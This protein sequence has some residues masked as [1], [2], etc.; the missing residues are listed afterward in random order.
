MACDL[1]TGYTWAGCDGIPGG[2]QVVGFL[3]YQ[4]KGVTFTVTNGVITAWTPLSAKTFKKYEIRPETGF[5]TDNAPKDPK[6]GG[7]AYAPTVNLTLSTLETT[8]RRE[9][10]L[11]QQNN[12]IVMTKDNVGKFRVGG[13]Y[14]GMQLTDLQAA[15]GTLFADGQKSI[16]NFAGVDT[17]PMLEM[18][19]AL[20]A[21][22]M[23]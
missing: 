20:A 2:I 1:T 21:T 14:Y 22:L 12:L 15:S 6:T 4:Y 17:Q 16:M 13:F 7:Y 11:L 10:L 23:P 3:E 8:T 5:F 9:I 18:T 19:S